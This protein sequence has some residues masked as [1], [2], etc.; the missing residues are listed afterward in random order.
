MLLRPATL[1]TRM[2][3]YNND[4]SLRSEIAKNGVAW[5]YKYDKTY[6]LQQKLQRVAIN[7]I[8]QFS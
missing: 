7:R 8:F 1:L 4:Y 3:L 5:F 2:Y 6:D